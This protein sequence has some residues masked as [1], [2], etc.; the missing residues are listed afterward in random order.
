MNF[1]KYKLSNWY[2]DSIRSLDEYREILLKERNSFSGTKSQHDSLEKYHSRIMQEKT[3]ALKL[4]SNA[5]YMQLEAEFWEDAFKELGISLQHP[6][7]DLLKSISY[8][9]G[10]SGGYSEIFYFANI[11]SPFLRD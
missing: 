1:E 11:L 5:K 9:K 8:D 10:H 4:K 3:N 7:A 2:Q 6:K